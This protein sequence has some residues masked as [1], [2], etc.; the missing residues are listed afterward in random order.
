MPTTSAAALTLSSVSGRSGDGT[1]EV[2]RS[3][4]YPGEE[5]RPAGE[6]PTHPI[7][8]ADGGLPRSRTVLP[9]TR[10]RSRLK[11]AL[12]CRSIWADHAIWRVPLRDRHR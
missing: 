4:V 3:I 11:G 8:T 10:C 1:V 2:M 7:L 5:E 6:L 12:S 9:L